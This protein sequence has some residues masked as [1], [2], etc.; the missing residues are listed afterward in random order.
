VK[1]VNLTVPTMKTL[2]LFLF[3]VSCLTGCVTG[4]DGSVRAGKFTIIQSGHN[5]PLS[6]NGSNLNGA[7]ISQDYK[8]APQP[9]YIE[10][11][12]PLVPKVE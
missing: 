1:I 5:D 6:P 10:R 11:V 3:L 9:A 12:V 2:F 8:R 4:P 7:W